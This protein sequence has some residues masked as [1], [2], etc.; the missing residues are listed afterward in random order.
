MQANSA[1][2]LRLIFIRSSHIPLIG[3]AHDSFLLKDR[4]EKIEQTVAEMREIILQ[5]SR[6]LLDFD[7]R[8]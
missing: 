7:L 5:A 6:D 3:C 1:E 4:T 2:L 8:L